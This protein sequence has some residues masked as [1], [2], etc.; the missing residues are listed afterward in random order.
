[1]KQ[2]ARIVLGS[3]IIQA[4]RGALKADE[5]VLLYPVVASATTNGWTLQVRGI[6]YERERQRLLTALMAR[7]VG[8]NVAKLPPT[9]RS[10]WKERSQYF[11]VDNE[12]GKKL[13]LRFGQQEYVL[14][15]SGANGHF[16][17]TLQMDRATFP[18]VPEQFTATNVTITCELCSRGAAPRSSSL[19]VHFVG[20]SGLSVISDIDDTIKVSNVR[21]REELIRNTFVRPFQPVPGMAEVYQEWA[22]A[23]RQFHY[24][25]ASPWQLFLPLSGFVRSNGF[26]AG[27]FHMKTFRVKDRSFVSL[28]QSPE[29]YKPTVI[30]SLFKQFPKRRYVLVGDSGEK[31]P[32]IYGALARK[33]PERVEKIYIRDVT[34]EPTSSARYRKAFQGVPKD[35]WQIFKQPSEI[36]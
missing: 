13:L 17:A 26:P 11:L 33:H 35:R 30:D 16:S 19:E 20:E 12:R 5:E 36:R 3:L 4:H 9:E 1:M 18:N 34:D 14:G 32:E 25:T 29:R 6:V 10:I 22:G 21:Q 28:F 15:V 27:A 2:L 23:G 7:L 31:D 24:V 8:L